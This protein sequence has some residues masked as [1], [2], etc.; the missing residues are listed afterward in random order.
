VLNG[1]IVFT[2]LI[3]FIALIC[4]L[5][6]FLRSFLIALVA[7]IVLNM[8]AVLIVLLVE[9]VFYSAGSTCML[10]DIDVLVATAKDAT[11]RM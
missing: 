9:D 10:V 3:I 7:S 4:C 11:V 6:S 2:V 1:L 8:L 5:F